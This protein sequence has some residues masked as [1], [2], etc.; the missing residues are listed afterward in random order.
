MEQ[1]LLWS[2]N[3]HP[4]APLS[5]SAFLKN[6]ITMLSCVGSAQGWDWRVGPSHDELVVGAPVVARFR[7]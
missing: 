1:W 6:R 2:L 5:S 4:L 7:R 3:L